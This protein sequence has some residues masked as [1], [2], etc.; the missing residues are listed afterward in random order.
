MIEKKMEVNFMR[1]VLDRP[2]VIMFA[3]ACSGCASL[4]SS[5]RQDLTINSIPSGAYVELD[6]VL[7]TTP[8]TLSLERKVK[9]RTLTIS[10]PGYETAEIRIGR[11]LNPWLAGNVLLGYGLPV[12]ATIDF[13]N[14]SAY[15]LDKENVQVTLQPTQHASSKDEQPTKPLALGLNGDIGPR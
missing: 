6:G 13:V 11:K 8:A 2:L 12:G 14:G 5:P 3:V 1:A 10:K 4:L 9:Q 15:Q 7:A